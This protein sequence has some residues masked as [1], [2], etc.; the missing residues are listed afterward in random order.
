MKAR[1]IGA[2]RCQ[3]AQEE[4]ES[5]LSSGWLIASSRTVD[6]GLL[7]GFNDENNTRTFTPFILA[8]IAPKHDPTPQDVE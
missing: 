4:G 7:G 8:L 5:A 6:G 3:L 1:L 2:L